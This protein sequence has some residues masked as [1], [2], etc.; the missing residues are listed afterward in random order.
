MGKRTYDF[1]EVDLTQSV[2]QKLLEDSLLEKTMSKLW[3]LDWKDILNGLL[4]AVI[5]NVVMYLL[6]IFSSLYQLVINGDPFVINIDFKAIVVVAI[7]SALTYLSKRFVS[8]E[9]GNV[10]QK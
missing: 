1:I 2:G 8:N 5:G 6:V 3:E 7:F 9:N 4:F 10:L